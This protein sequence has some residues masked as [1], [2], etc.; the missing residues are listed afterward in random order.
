MRGFVIATFTGLFLENVQESAATTACL[1]QRK[2]SVAPVLSSV[3][4]ILDKHSYPSLS[5][6]I[7]KTDYF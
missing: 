5:L 6:G 1:K 3:S 2:K 4:G 7:I